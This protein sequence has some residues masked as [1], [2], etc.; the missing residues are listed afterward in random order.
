MHVSS[1]QAQARQSREFPSHMQAR[2]RLLV[3]RGLVVVNVPAHEWQTLWAAAAGGAGA[4]LD[5]GGVPPTLGEAGGGSREEGSTDSWGGRG[6]RGRG[7]AVCG[8]LQALLDGACA[9]GQG[10]QPGGIETS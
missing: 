4:D 7:Q 3:S 2:R 10:E 8:Y 1:S 9:A 6:S 5:G